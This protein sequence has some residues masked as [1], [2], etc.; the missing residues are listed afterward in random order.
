MSLAGV[1]AM[2]R[3]GKRQRCPWRSGL[4]GYD[5]FAAVV[6]R[7]AWMVEAGVFFGLVGACIRRKLIKIR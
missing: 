5:R 7:E 2:A 4:K 6:C 3:L 1:V